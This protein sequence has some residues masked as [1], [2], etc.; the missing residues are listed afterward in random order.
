ML[1]NV[2]REASSYLKFIIEYYDELPEHVAFIHGHEKAWHQSLDLMKAIGCAKHDVYDYVSLNGVFFLRKDDSEFH[3]LATVLWAK[4]FQP[5]V[6]VQYPANSVLHDS[7]AQFIVSRDAIRRHKK[8]TY[9]Y[10]LNLIF[11]VPLPKIT[12]G[13][14]SAEKFDSSFLWAIFLEFVWHIIFGE[15]ARL[16]SY[17]DYLATHFTCFQDELRVLINPP[18]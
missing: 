3:A 16:D 2:G 13:E 18:D 14:F 12:T 15:P 10:W 17:H 1:P 5:Y 6:K 11:N 8:E 4:Y 9:A 7:C